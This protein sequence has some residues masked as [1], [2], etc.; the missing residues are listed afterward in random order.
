[1]TDQLRKE[2]ALKGPL[3]LN[4]GM[5]AVRDLLGQSLASSEP[6]LAAVMEHLK[7]GS[8]KNIRAALLLAAAS[9]ADG[10]V[11]QDAVAAAAALEI[12]HLASLVHDDVIDD[13][14]VRR[15][16]ASIQQ[17]FGKKTAVISGDYLF[18]LSFSLIADLASDYTD[19]IKLFTNAISSLCLGELRQHQHNRDMDLSVLGYLR[20]IAGKTAA[21][22]YLALYAG[23]MLAECPP[24]EC[25]LLGRIGYNLGILFQLTDD[26]LDYESSSSQLGKSARHDLAEGVVTLPLIYALRQKPRLKELARQTD[27]TADQI[28]DIVS[29]VRDLG[30]LA[31]AR[32][33]SDKYYAKTRQLLDRLADQ[34]KAGLI[35]PLLDKVH[36]R[37]A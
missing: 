19:Q 7:Q 5:A 3:P 17:K 35:L 30:G 9:S 28:K 23:G 11:S 26:L 33:L 32:R 14:P 6:V 34:R 13:A 27:L 4:S 18:C 29:S 1:M 21:L 22:F 31:K 36:Q 15:G 20:I 2:G 12:L 16:Q 10:Q 37:N 24:D 25:R 8:G